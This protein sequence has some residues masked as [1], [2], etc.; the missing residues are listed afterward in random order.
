MTYNQYHLLGAIKQVRLSS[1]PL[2][3]VARRSPGAAIAAMQDLTAMR[4]GVLVPYQR[5]KG[6]IPKSYNQ[7]VRADTRRA[8]LSAD[9]G[10]L[11]KCCHSGFQFNDGLDHDRIQC[12]T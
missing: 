4:R 7:L 11:Q 6:E 3:E 9:P 1:L 10:Y 8:G 5:Q 12:I 2:Q